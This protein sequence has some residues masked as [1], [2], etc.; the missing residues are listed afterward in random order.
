MPDV[1]LER[2]HTAALIADFY[3]GIM[4]MLPDATGRGVV[5]KAAAAHAAIPNS[6]DDVIC[7]L[8]AL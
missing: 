3:A 2:G 5:E 4:D 8:G 1:A 7:P 6:R